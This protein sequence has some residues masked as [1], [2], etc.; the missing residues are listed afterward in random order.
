MI[1]VICCFN[2]T[3]S[4]TRERARIEALRFLKK[5]DLRLLY[6]LARDIM[7]R[8]TRPKQIDDITHDQRTIDFVFFA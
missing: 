1:I 6:N 8:M 2:A 3:S 7:S 5:S 4:H